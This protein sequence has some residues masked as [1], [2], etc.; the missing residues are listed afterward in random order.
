MDK[1][2]SLN[3]ENA[4][5]FVDIKRELNKTKTTEKQSKINFKLDLFL[6]KELNFNWYICVR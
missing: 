2:K 4:R 5:F 6:Q 1:I 3:T